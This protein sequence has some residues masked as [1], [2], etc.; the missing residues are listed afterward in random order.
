VCKYL[1]QYGS[2][3]HKAFHWLKMDPTKVVGSKLTSQNSCMLLPWLVAHDLHMN[4]AAMVGGLQPS[5]EDLLN[6]VAP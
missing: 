4:S 3:M 2:I 5:H 1:V 6:A